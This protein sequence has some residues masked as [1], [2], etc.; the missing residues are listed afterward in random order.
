MKEAVVVKFT[1]RQLELFVALA[2]YPTLSEAAAFLHFSVVG[3][4][5][6]YG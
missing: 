1:F 5:R 3:D 6:R 2:D 4:E